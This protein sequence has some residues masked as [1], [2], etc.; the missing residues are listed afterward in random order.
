MDIKIQRYGDSWF[1][2]AIVNAEITIRYDEK[3]DFMSE[4][5][6]LLDRYGI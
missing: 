3:T 5:N 1:A 6:E 4:M 2:R